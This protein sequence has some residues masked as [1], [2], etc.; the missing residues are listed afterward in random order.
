MNWL[1]TSPSVSSS[2]TQYISRG[3]VFNNL[4]EITNIFL[5]T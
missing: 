5:N 2:N 4:P 3:N 1:E